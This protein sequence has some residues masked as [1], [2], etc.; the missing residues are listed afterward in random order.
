M[1]N[2]F[3]GHIF[4]SSLIVSSIPL[5][6][7][8][9]VCI[10]EFGV[11]SS[12]AMIKHLGIAIFLLTQSSMCAIKKRI[13]TSHMHLTCANSK[14][15][16]D[17]SVAILDGCKIDDYKEQRCYEEQLN[18][19]TIKSQFSYE[20]EDNIIYHLPWLIDRLRE[21]VAQNLESCGLK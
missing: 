11:T 3:F 7:R 9:S 5:N 10:E 19:R 15:N 2:I 6:S 4:Q 17:N 20:R 12:N 1:Q 14:M 8:F 21:M 16:E 18:F 13:N